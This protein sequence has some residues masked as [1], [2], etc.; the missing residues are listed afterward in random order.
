MLFPADIEGSRES[1]RVPG[2]AQFAGTVGRLVMRRNA[3]W[4]AHNEINR[5]AE[6]PEGVPHCLALAC[7]R[8]RDAAFA[9]LALIASGEAAS[10][11]L[12]R[13]GR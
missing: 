5:K 2:K 12:S 13:G 6:T 11:E 9:R 8:P 4:R 3:V 1:A 10:V 7:D